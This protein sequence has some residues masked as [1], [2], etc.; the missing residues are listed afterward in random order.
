MPASGRYEAVLLQKQCLKFL[1]LDVLSSATSKDRHTYPQSYPIASLTE[2]TL[3]NQ[4]TLGRSLDVSIDR[5]FI[6]GL[7]V[8]K[9]TV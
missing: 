7:Y 4:S 1:E 5:K 3:F 6:A 2:N 8:L 9:L